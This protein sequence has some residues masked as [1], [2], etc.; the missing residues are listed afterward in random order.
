M[1]TFLTNLLQVQALSGLRQDESVARQA[2]INHQTASH[3]MDLAF[4]RDSTELSIPESYAVQGLS[5]A[6]LARESQGLN[7]ASQ[8]PAKAA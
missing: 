2:V 7:L 6:S 4:I 3:L 5:M 8:T 1:D